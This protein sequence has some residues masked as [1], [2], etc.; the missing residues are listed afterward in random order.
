MKRNRHAGRLQSDGVGVNALSDA[1]LD[2]VHHG[3]LEVLE[4][5]GVF[6]EDDQALAVFADAGCRVDRES[7]L[8][9]LPP[10]VV[11]DALG[12]CPPTYALCGRDPG[13]DFMMGSTRVGFVTF[14]EG[15]LINDLETGVN[16]ASTKQDVADITRLVDALADIDAVASPLGARDTG[17]AAPTAHGLEAMLNHT[18]KHVHLPM[19]TRHEAEAAVEMAA[20]V[21][22]GDDVL[23]DRPIVSGGCAIVSPLRLTKQFSDVTAVWARAGLPTLMISGVIAGATS[24]ATLAGSLVQHNAEMLAAITYAQ[25]VERGTK[26]LYGSFSAAM[27]M[28][29]GQD[30]VG[31]PE[32][33]LVSTCLPLLAH[34]YDLPCWM[35]GL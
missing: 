23:R 11:A 29:F 31:T 19:M 5:T 6:V 7:N 1:D 18:T 20:L 14:C 9:K 8:A 24:P 4:R 2:A 10:H 17:V 27:D 25:L 13:H 32:M 22:G 15:I 33:S 21:A 34:R 26:V 12:S 28:R 3:S 35:A 30:C 16:R